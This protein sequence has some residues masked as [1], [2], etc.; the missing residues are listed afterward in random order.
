MNE[1]ST[2]S[3]KSTDDS[4]AESTVSSS[5][6]MV[7]I[8]QSDIES[9]PYHITQPGTYILSENLRFGFNVESEQHTADHALSPNDYTTPCASFESG[10]RVQSN[11][12]V[13]DLN[14]HLMEMTYP[15]YVQQRVFSLLELGVS[16]DDNTTD[17]LTA[18]TQST[19]S[20]VVIQNGALGLTSHRA[21]S[22]FDVDGLT[23]S[24][25][26]IANF[27]AAGLRCD[28]CS[29]VTVIGSVIGPQNSNI[30]VLQRYSHSRSLLPRLR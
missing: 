1:W 2:D 9:G 10:I 12:V 15:F 14:G 27:D 6:S 21:I 26:Q 20:S 8:S 19:V 7:Y 4:N 16:A 30:P 5:S 11:D 29:S 25:V 28:G 22:G 13:I 17:S 3:Q 23:V 24:N 18:S